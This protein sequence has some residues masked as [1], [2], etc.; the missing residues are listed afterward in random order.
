MGIYVELSSLQGLINGKASDIADQLRRL[1]EAKTEINREQ[2]LLLG[3]IRNLRRPD[4]SDQW[5]G[6]L[7]DRY[8]ADREAS[9]QSM[10][11]IGNEQYDLYQRVID[12]RIHAL[13]AQQSHFSFLGSLAHEAESLLHKGEGYAEDVSAKIN[14]IK[15]RVF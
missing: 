6:S 3:E 10:V 8:D 13:E 12:S 7:S 2:N 1:R 4:L 11:Q 14:H 5:V 15:G 9:Y